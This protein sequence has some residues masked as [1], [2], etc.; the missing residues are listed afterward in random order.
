MKRSGADPFTQMMQI[1]MD[2]TLGDD[3][4]FRQHL[5]LF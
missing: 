1:L 3:D 4:P 2:V 5:R